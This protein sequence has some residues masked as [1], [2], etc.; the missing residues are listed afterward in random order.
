MQIIVDNRET[1]IV[2]LEELRKNTPFKDLTLLEYAFSAYAFVIRGMGMMTFA[3]F[4]DE[5]EKVYSI[6]N[7]IN[8]AVCE[9]LRKYSK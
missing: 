5:I 2:D 9:M 4:A 7:L 8:A 3:Q 1:R 6:S